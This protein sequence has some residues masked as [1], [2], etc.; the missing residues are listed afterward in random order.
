MS[1][2]RRGRPAARLTKRAVAPALVR[3]YFLTYKL[4]PGQLAAPTVAIPQVYGCA[5]ALR[6]ISATQRD[7]A[8]KY[9][10][11]KEEFQVSSI[12]C[13]RRALSLN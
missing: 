9:G 4:A 3:H 6:V 12:R 11:L 10:N 7:Y 5:E 13:R 8:K 1:R 2:R